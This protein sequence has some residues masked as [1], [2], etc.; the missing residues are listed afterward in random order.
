MPEPPSEQPPD[1]REIR[2]LG[3]S[4]ERLREMAR[5]VAALVKARGSGWQDREARE[6]A[7]QT[8]TDD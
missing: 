2:P 4:K 6:A 7:E 3:I 8:A 1:P 5:E